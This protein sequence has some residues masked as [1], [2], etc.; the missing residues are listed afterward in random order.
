MVCF[1]YVDRLVDLPA[2]TKQV[3]G[4]YATLA[5]PLF[6]MYISIVL[7][8]H[9]VDVNVHPT[10]RRVNLMNQ[11][12][13]CTEIVA[14]MRQHLETIDTSRVRS[15]QEILVPSRVFSVENTLRNI[16]P[17]YTEASGARKHAPQYLV[18]TDHKARK[19]DQFFARSQ[20]AS[21]VVNF[22]NLTPTTQSGLHISLENF[23]P[24]RAASNIP[25]HVAQDTSMTCDEPPSVI[26][27]TG[28]Q[29]SVRQAHDDPEYMAADKAAKVATGPPEPREWIN[30]QLV[31]VAALIDIEL[32]THDPKLDEVFRAYTIVG[33]VTPAL[34]LIQHHTRLM[35]VDLAGLL[36]QLFYQISLQAFANFSKIQL[37]IPIDIQAL[38]LVYLESHWEPS[39]V[40]QG[41]IASKVSEILTRHAPMLLEY[42]SIGI[43]EGFVLSLPI[44]DLTNSRDET[45]MGVLDSLAPYLPE[46]I[47][48]LGTKPDYTQEQA[49]FES[50]SN[51]LARMYAKA[52]ISHYAKREQ[53]QSDQVNSGSAL[54]LAMYLKCTSKTSGFISTVCDLPKLYSVFERC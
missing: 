41:E 25:V 51:A 46:F 15:V 53:Q 54:D 37:A 38:C 35:M 43:D 14:A 27:L 4:M 22:D 10:K 49:C 34:I 6:F 31:S 21:Q 23:Q 47:M 30:V 1:F 20:G 44:L 50:I 48:A 45:Q 12:A 24:S 32:E 7:P 5:R 19:L 18:R 33:H 40:P 13:I 8:P 16:Q 36:I 3:A 11:D 17:K 29:P 39:M 2:L 52:T 28:D 9:L 42:Y 26:D